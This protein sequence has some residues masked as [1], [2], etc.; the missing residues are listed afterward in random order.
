[1]GRFQAALALSILRRFDLMAVKRHENGML[2][3]NGLKGL[4]GIMIPEVSGRDRPA[5]NRFPIVFKDRGLRE[6]AAKRL[7][8]A[9]I[10]S[11]RMYVRPLHHMFDLGYNAGDF[12]N[13]CYA[14]EGLLTLPVHPSVGRERLSKAVDIIR[15]VFV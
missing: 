6:I 10:E 7:R 14:A 9:G 13:A 11:S 2:L 5:F 12:Q 1:M 8:H 15:G 3:M 4:P